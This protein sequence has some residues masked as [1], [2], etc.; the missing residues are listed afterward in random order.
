M[1]G[2]IDPA[3]QPVDIIFL[4]HV[5]DVF[6]YKLRGKYSGNLRF[7]LKARLP[8]LPPLQDPRIHAIEAGG[9][10]MPLT[11]LIFIMPGASR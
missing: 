9:S 6:T 4:R 11:I 2:D 3:L 7:G 10:G 5:D 1:D 8:F